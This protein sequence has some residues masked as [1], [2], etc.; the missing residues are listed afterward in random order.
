MD[1][2][3]SKLGSL[4][5]ELATCWRTTRERTEFPGGRT[6]LQ[7]ML[8]PNGRVLS[9]SAFALAKGA[10]RT[11]IEAAGSQ[12]GTQFPALPKG[13]SSQSAVLLLRFVEPGEADRSQTDVRVTATSLAAGARII[14]DLKWDAETLDLHQAVNSLTGARA[15]SVSQVVTFHV[16]DAVSVQ[17][18][19]SIFSILHAAQRLR[20]A[21][22][23]GRT[24]K[25]VGW[26][27]APSLV[28]C[29]GAV[30][31]GT[32]LVR[33]VAGKLALSVA[34]EAV[35]PDTLRGAESASNL[36]CKLRSSTLRDRS[37]V[38]VETS[39]GNYGPVALLL[40]RVVGCGFHD[41]ALTIRP[42]PRW[43]R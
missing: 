18:L 11:C 20:L 9:A 36:I 23:D 38:Y 14:E 30:N 8:T 19:G 7:L 35:F 26:R 10:F 33:Q 21:R 43:R 41:A 17:A 5:D 27:P 42:I 3:A 4:L 29:H 28:V 15:N 22:L 12:V 24:W 31:A 1:S 34:T 13:A 2:P 37:D 6:Q 32:V 40:A 39:E 25:D 16:D